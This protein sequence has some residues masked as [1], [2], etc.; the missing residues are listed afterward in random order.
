MNIPLDGKTLGGGIQWPHHASIA[1]MVTFDFDAELLRASRAQNKGT[2]IGFT[3]HSRGQ[4]GPTQGIQRCM[5]L[6]EKHNLNSTFFVPGAIAERY[7]D[8]VKKLHLQGHEI[9]YHGYQHESVRDIP[10]QQECA[11]MEKS[12]S[13]IESITGEKPVGHR[14]PESI[15]HSF[16][17]PLIAS[18]GYLYS[19]SMKDCD[20]PYTVAVGDQKIVELP[21]DIL[22]DDFTYFY[23]T[24]SDP[25][26]RSMYTPREVI[27]ILK[28]EFDALCEEGDKV[29]ILKLHPQLIGRAA[30]IHALDEFLT[31]IQR[32][33]A[34]ITTCK[35]VATYVLKWE[36]N[37]HEN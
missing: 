18:R 15:M 2:K 37:N 10:E 5:E 16:T 30:R 29:L 8:I 14:A 31:Y 19:S 23:F 3:D 9:A 17:Y 32:Q 13:I 22:T 36:K 11:H 28:N 1:V 35:E 27:S 20:Y 25:A 34:W 7:P 21:N 26:N 24:F 12:E 6:L 4:Y 33:G